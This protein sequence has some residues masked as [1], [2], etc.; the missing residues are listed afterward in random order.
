[1]PEI[2]KKNYVLLVEGQTDFL[3]LYEKG[4]KNVLATSGTAFSTKHANALA[5][6]TNRVILT[7]DSD[8]AGVNAAIRTGYILLQN[9]FEVRVI[10]LGDGLDP[11]DYFKLKENSILTFKELIKTAFHPINYIINKK[12]IHSLGASDK[13]KFLNECIEEIKL[14]DDVIIRNDLIKRLSDELGVIENEVIGR[15]AELK[16]NR[17]YNKKNE[18]DKK[19]Q[20]KHYDS[21]SDKAQFEI[22]KLFIHNQKLSK[23]ISLSLFDNKL[24]YNIVKTIIDN[25]NRYKNVAQLLEYLGNAPEERNLVASLAV[26]VPDKEN[27]LNILSD[28]IE[29][30]ENQKIKNKISKLRNQIRIIEESGEITSEEMVLELIALQ[31][32]TSK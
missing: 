22:L 16:S 8:N 24:C 15:F 32:K 21:K 1:M 13:S 23:D 29:T 28:C 4:F 3:R 9:G 20:I 5:K 30:L 12:N 26:D 6:Y 10:D 19:N 17:R 27:E 18:K 14:V 25:S 7:Y 2:R 11:D 31:K